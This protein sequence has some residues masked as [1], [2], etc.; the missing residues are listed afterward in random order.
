MK[1]IKEIYLEGLPIKCS[2]FITSSKEILSTGMKKHIISYDLNTDKME[3]ISNK[4]F[5]EYFHKQIDTFTI[6]PDEKYLA[7]FNTEGIL[8]YNFSGD[9]II[10]SA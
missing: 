7:M 4:N 8:Y 6:S 3:K 10:L 5:T 1:L 2:K 9:I